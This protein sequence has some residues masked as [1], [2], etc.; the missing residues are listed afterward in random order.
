MPNIFK[1]RRHAVIAIAIAIVVL[2]FITAPIVPEGWPSSTWQTTFRYNCPAGDNSTQGL[3]IP[4]TSSISYA[5]LKV[6]FIYDQ[7][8]SPPLAFVVGSTINLPCIH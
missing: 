7:Q 6:G 4:Y 5:V 8:L 1:T 3:P 2:F